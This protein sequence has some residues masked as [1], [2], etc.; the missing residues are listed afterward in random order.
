MEDVGGIA[1]AIT[2]LASSDGRATAL[3]GLAPSTASSPYHKKREYTPGLRGV[4]VTVICNWE[5]FNSLV[6]QAL[7]C[8]VDDKI[9]TSA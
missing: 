3:S 6:V 8:R 1:A 9:P 7:P 5:A 2:L 4:K